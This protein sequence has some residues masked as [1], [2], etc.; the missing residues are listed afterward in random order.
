MW[1]EI[2][3]NRT[4][5][6]IWIFPVSVSSPLGAISLLQFDSVSVKIDLSDLR[7]NEALAPY[8]RQTVISGLR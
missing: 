3:G 2:N 6:G 8:L 7:V 4:P 1:L 5:R